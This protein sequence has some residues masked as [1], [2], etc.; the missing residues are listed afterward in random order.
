MLKPQFIY[1]FGWKD[2]GNFQI[3]YLHILVIYFGVEDD[4]LKFPHETIQIYLIF[5]LNKTVNKGRISE[6][7]QDVFDGY[8]GKI[9]FDPNLWFQHKALV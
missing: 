6:P 8:W 4:I 5:Y 2:N 7:K 3:L 9:V 1:F